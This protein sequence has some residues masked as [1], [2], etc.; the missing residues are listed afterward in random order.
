MKKLIIIG[1]SL[2]IVAICFIIFM[3]RTK[4]EGSEVPVVPNVLPESISIDDGS[5][6]EWGDEFEE[7]LP[8]EV[9]AEQF[10]QFIN[11]GDYDTAS[12]FIE[13]NVLMDYISYHKEL[14]PQDAFISYLK[15]FNPN[16][17]KSLRISKSKWDGYYQKVTVSTKLNTDKPNTYTLSFREFSER[18]HNGK[19]KYWL[20]RPQLRS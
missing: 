18:A 11:I 6:A 13:P 8:P 14:S 3:S 20:Y 15:L 7:T 10:F 4:N 17:L 12:G 2:W 16:E 9:V 19:E 5:A 1:I